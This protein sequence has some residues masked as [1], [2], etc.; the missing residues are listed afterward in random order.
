MRLLGL[1]LCTVLTRCATLV[2]FEIADKDCLSG[3]T[4]L[5]CNSAE[6]QGSILKQFFFLF[7]PYLMDKGKEVL[8]G[9]F[10]EVSGKI[11]GIETKGRRY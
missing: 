6:R 10:L 1:N 3:I 11:V 8:S 2:L 4:D 5:K 9:L 7:Q